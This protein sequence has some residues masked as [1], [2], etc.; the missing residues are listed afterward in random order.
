MASIDYEKALSLL[1][2]LFLEAEK[3]FNNNKTPAVNPSII[4][5]ADILFL[6]LTQS[7]REVL[8]GCGL[9]RLLD[10][11]INIRFPYIN[12]GDNAFNGRTLDERVVN[13]FFQDRLIPSS[14]GPY[15]ASFRRSVK[16]IPE[17]ATGLRDKEGYAALLDYI[18][19]LETE[20]PKDVR[21]L[22]IYILYRFIQLRNASNIPLSQISRFSLEQYR[23]LVSMLIQIQSGGLIPVLLVV[24][25][26]RTIKNCFGLKWV[27]EYHGI[28]VSDKASGSGGDIIV[29]QSDNIIL[30]I[31]VTERL[32]E[33]SRVVSTFNSKIVKSG[34]ED[35]LFVYSDS[36]PTEEALQIARKYFSQGHEINFLQIQEWIVNNLGTIGAKGRNVFNH[37]LISL[38]N[39]REVSASIKIAWNDIVKKIV[40]I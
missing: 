28:N 19:A 23:A 34:I 36:K 33:K 37:E 10:R 25:M 4:K 30:A 29:K 7:L 21:L 26:L 20:S 5:A 31:E 22:V 6:S 8:L 1:N 32:I 17:T 38:F 3:Y 13:P 16:F 9:A 11:S 18:G 15:L 39:N 27:I 24:S 12:Q 35:Y 40:E 14:K 2:E